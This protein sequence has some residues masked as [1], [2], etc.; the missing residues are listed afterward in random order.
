MLK[1][2]TILITK[3]GQP[4]SGR[5]MTY[6]IILIIFPLCLTFSAKTQETVDWNAYMKLLQKADTLFQK[7]YFAES[8]VAYSNAFTFSNQHFSEGDR[9]KAARAWAK[10]G[11]LDSAKANLKLDI[12]AGFYKLDM[13]K[14]ESSF[15]QLKKQKDW[16]TILNN[17]EMNLQ[18]QNK[19]LGK[20]KNIKPKLENILVLDQK[21]RK[22]YYIKLPALGPNADETKKLLQQM[23]RTDR[24]NQ[25]YI[26]K[27]L[28]EHGWVD[29][30]II[31]FEASAALFLVVQHADSATQ[32]KYLPL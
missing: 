5:D 32:E 24:L 21:F 17:V 11:Q 3:N 30:K 20:F 2:V 16:K 27:I 14:K 23:N 4:I 7:K 25:K 15:S 13:L 10:V 12:E 26:S 22:E 18:I 28:D 31:G 6:R 9:Y 29:Y 19:K 8:A 1:P